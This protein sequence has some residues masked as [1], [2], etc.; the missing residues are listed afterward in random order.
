M[1]RCLDFFGKKFE[2]FHD[3]SFGHVLVWLFAFHGEDEVHQVREA[4]FGL[5]PDKCLSKPT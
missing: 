5:E 1:E 2:C 3:L 4:T